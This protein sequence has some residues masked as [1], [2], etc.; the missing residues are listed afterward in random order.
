MKLFRID[1]PP[2]RWLPA[3]ARFG[4]ELHP[5]EYTESGDAIV[6]DGE[7]LTQHGSGSAPSIVTGLSGTSG[8]Q[9]VT[10][11]VYGGVSEG[12]PLALTL[13]W[14]AATLRLVGRGISLDDV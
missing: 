13:Q 6:V 7:T 4:A 5:G 3:T 8:Q 14:P 12:G 11:H 9:T 1:V 10:Y 2:A